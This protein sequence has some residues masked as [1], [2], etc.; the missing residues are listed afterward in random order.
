MQEFRNCFVVVFICTIHFHIL[1]DVLSVLIRQV[2]LDYDCQDAAQRLPCCSPKIGVLENFVL[3]FL[4]IVSIKT[5]VVFVFTKCM[6]PTFMTWQPCT[7]H[8]SLQFEIRLVNSI[9]LELSDSL[10]KI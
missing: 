5:N 2:V 8:S 7:F 1:D 3:R 10:I 6:H 4:S 9:G